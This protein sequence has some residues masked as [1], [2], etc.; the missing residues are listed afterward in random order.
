M[1]SLG[2]KWAAWINKCN[3]MQDSC[4]LQHHAEFIADHLESSIEQGMFKQCLVP[5]WAVQYVAVLKLDQS[6]CSWI[7]SRPVKIQAV[8]ELQ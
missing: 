6:V 3:A 2:K 4:Q 8:A 1:V 5:S 7:E